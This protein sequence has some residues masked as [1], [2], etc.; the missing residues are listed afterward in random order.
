M[1]R[2]FAI[3]FVAVF[4]AG[5]GGE[6]TTGDDASADG[7]VDDA[8]SEA[9]P[10]WFDANEEPAPKPDA[11]IPDASYTPTC[12][13]VGKYVGV[14]HC[15]DG[16]YCSGGCPSGQAC[17]CAG[18]QGGCPWPLVCCIKPGGCISADLCEQW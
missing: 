9:P 6:T 8:Q 7:T 11:M 5:C 3:G 15:C 2:C 10:F 1:V 16:G 14:A 13:D 17:W 18:V 12:D 4:A